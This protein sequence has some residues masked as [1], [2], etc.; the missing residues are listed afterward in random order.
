MIKKIAGTM[1]LIMS[2]SLPVLVI[3][4]DAVG[5]TIPLAKGGISNPLKSDLDTFP[6]FVSKV[7]ETAV[8]ILIPFIVLAF[9]YTG[10]L[11]IKAQGNPETLK[12]AKSS[13]WWS[14]IG[15]FILLGAW[16]FAQIIGQTVSTIT[17]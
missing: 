13:L 2:L 9:V 7:T 1:L 16:S 4:Q 8:N 14:V 5:G 12:E 6:K 17:N 10:F 3:A 11:F 15:A